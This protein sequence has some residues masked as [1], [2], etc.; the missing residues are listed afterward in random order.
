MAQSST[1]DPQTVALLGLGE[2]GSAIAR[3]LCGEGGWRE[4]APNRQVIAIDIALGE[5]ARGQAM[6]AR[7][8]ALE[9][10]A[11]RD[12]TDA[13]SSADLVISVV[14]GEDAP[15]A[16]RMACAW[17]RPGTIYADFNAITGPQVKAVASELTPAG[18]DF[19]DVAVMG[20]FMAMGHRIPLVLAGPRAGDLADF[21]EAIGAP[22]KVLSDGIGDASAVKILRSILMKGIEALS[23]EFLVAARRQGL[24]DQVLDNLGDV[25]A[26]GLA[27]FVKVMAITHLTH[28]KRRME[29]IEKA[30]QNLD[31]TGV[32][33]LMSEAIRRSHQRTVDAGL[34][35]AEIADVDLD[36]AIRI[37]DEQVV[38]PRN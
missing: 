21:A 24:V 2:A 19:V 35:P 10:P 38:D 9:L 25:D 15:V 36:T 29:E 34:D 31:E 37:L 8:E 33:A 27:K 3:G 22:A 20:S 26:L 13:L 16:A 5:G 23:V 4:A 30:M 14:T 6:A 12:Y 28:A 11:V 17:L 7:A 1:F 32:P 18:I